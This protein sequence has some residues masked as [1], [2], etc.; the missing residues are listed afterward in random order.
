MTAFISAHAGELDARAASGLIRE[1]HGDV[2]AEHVLLNGAVRVVDCVEFDL[3]MRTLDVADDLAFLAMDLAALCGE[4]FVPALIDSYRA[5]GGDCGSDALV[6]FFAV[7][8][9][10]VRTKIV[11]VRAMQERTASAARGQATPQSRDLLGLAER[12]SWRARLPLAIIVCGVP[13]SGKSRLARVL[14]EASGLPWLS[15]DA[16]RKRLAGIGRGRRAPAEVYGPE[17]SARTY[18]ELG[19]LAAREV[20]AQGGAVVDATFRY[21]RDRIAFSRSFGDVA[22]VLFVECQAPAAL[23]AARSV[24]RER[25]P[26]RLSDADL[27]VV[28]RERSTWE[29]LDEIPATAQFVLHTDRRLDEIIKD[30]YAMLDRRL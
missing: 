22:K 3:D 13:A 4:R 23:L 24:R 14:A 11:R 21:R 26:V 8:R 12:F 7:H 28:M 2:R 20:D 19:R 17:W 18:A 10:L 9:A 1:C 27:E 5:A 25:D 15:S 29:P 16:T 6:A 30:V